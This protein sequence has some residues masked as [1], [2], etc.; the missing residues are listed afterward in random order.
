MRCF[1]CRLVT[2]VVLLVSLTTGALAAAPAVATIPDNVRRIVFLGDSITYGG[3]YVNAFAAYFATRHP[4]RPLEI[5]NVGLSSETVSG[6]SEEGHAKGAFPRPDLHER[7]GRV[8]AATKPDLVVAC[9]GMND[10]IYLPLEAER[11]RRY[12]DG[13][14]RLRAAVAAVGARIVHATPAPYDDGRGGKAGYGA[15]LERYAAWLLEQRAAGWEVI[16]LNGPM[17]AAL[18]AHRKQEPDFY[19][20]KD[21]VHPGDYGHWLMA[22]EILRHFGARDLEGVESAAAMVA[23]LPRGPE[24]LDLVTRRQTLLRD[25]WLTATGHQRPGVRAGLPLTEA[26][27]QARAIDVKLAAL[28]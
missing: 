10:G 3:G 18:A 5:L 17:R 27:A 13:L 1:S 4:G 25:A 12:Q 26:E 15:V 19:L 20:S 7:L 22:R 2:L 28:R 6:L 14:K 24:I 8:L 23:T 11:F 9:Y 16:D 21:G